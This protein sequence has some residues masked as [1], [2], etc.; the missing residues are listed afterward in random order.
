MN[1]YNDDV[2]RL[3]LISFALGILLGVIY[4]VAREIFSTMFFSDSIKCKRVYL[5]AKSVLV[6]ISDFLFCILFGCCALVLMYNAN[7]GVFRGGAYFCMLAGYVSYRLTLRRITNK[8]L[9]FLLFV[10]KWIL[11]KILQ[12]LSVPIRLIFKLLYL[13]IGKFV[14]III[15]G[16][17]NKRLEAKRKREEKVRALSLVPVAES[18]KEEYVDIK[19]DPENHQ[20]LR[21]IVRRR[22]S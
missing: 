18:G 17:K 2:L 1:I 10:P 20:T 15:C 5:I 11:K 14:C 21:I 12:I 19:Q 9:Y 16:I 7:N 8:T 4:D 22:D 6:F 3:L 13:T